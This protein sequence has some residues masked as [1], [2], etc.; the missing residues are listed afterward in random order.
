M[1][2]IKR[3]LAGIGILILILVVFLVGSV[4]IDS[5]IG[6]GRIN[7]LVNI[8]I[9][10]PAGPDIPAYIAY[11]TT[12]GPHPTVIM[13]H[14]FW[15][16]KQEI[17]GKADALAEQ[18]YLVIAPSMFQNNTTN[19]IPRAIYQVISTPQEQII[20]N[21]DAVFAYLISLDEVQ[22]DHIAI[23]GFCFGGGSSLRYSLH[24]NQIAAT[25]ILYGSLIT[26]PEQLKALPGP[27]LGIFGGAD[28]SIPL[29]EVSAFETA[30]NDLDIPNQITIYDGQPHA[31][32]QSME[33][34]RQ[35]GAQGQAWDEVVKFLQDNLQT[36]PQSKREITPTIKIAGLDW[37]YL[38]ML[39]YEHTIGHS[40][41]H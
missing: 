6:R 18:G 1:K 27:V 15:G 26:D 28:Q 19:W 37:Q 2:I 33:E 21:L 8:H 12:P 40:H 7:P 3:I 30:L 17:V 10:N 39:A 24:N 20:N 11:P 13:I 34:I 5:L 9:A 4:I 38:V 25:V 41:Q 36:D 32:V 22:A 31:F 35:G 16:L 29:E 14:E 23:M